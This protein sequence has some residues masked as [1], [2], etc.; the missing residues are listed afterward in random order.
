[1][2]NQYVQTVK[3]IL[4]DLEPKTRTQLL[5]SK[6][7]KKTPKT[8]ALSDP[9]LFLVYV[10][11]IGN[12]PRIWTRSLQSL[13]I[14]CEN[15]TCLDFET[16]TST[17]LWKDM[18]IVKSSQ[19]TFC[20]TIDEILKMMHQDLSTSE[21][22]YFE[23]RAMGRLHSLCTLRKGFRLPT[24]P[25]SGKPW[26]LSEL[27]QIIGQLFLKTTNFQLL[28][29]YPEVIVFLKHYQEFYSQS[30][31]LNRDQMI[32]KIQTLFEKY[33][34]VF[35]QDFTPNSV[36]KDCVNR[37]LWK[38]KTVPKNLKTSLQLWQFILKEEK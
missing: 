1:M 24:H 26:T 31:S 29:S 13:H 23:T 12:D 25:Y 37:S 33:G 6:G 9:V 21:A 15:E 19:N 10:C 30:Q 34:L 28:Q 27:D 3:D 22:G 8:S 7:Y 17:Q 18:I 16:L 32:S 11:L 35:H 4:Q 36:T 14:Q 38:W 20:F 2:F 5:Q